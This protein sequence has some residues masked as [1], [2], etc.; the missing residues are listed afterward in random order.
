MNSRLKCSH[1]LG[2]KSSKAADHFRELKR[3]SQGWPDRHF[4]QL[5]KRLL[6]ASILVMPGTAIYFYPRHRAEAIR[7]GLE[8]QFARR[9][10]APHTAP[11]G[12]ESSDKAGFCLVQTEY[13]IGVSFAEFEAHCRYEFEFDRG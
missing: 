10:S 4:S 7:R 11:I 13:R 1:F 6:F 5:K 2:A 3:F 12:H 8:R 9:T